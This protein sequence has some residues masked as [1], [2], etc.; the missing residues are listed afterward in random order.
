MERG[1]ATTSV[2]FSMLSKKSS[3]SFGVVY[4]CSAIV[5]P[6]SRVFL[7]C[8]M[9]SILFKLKL[10]LKTKKSNQNMCLNKHSKNIDCL[11]INLS[12][13]EFA[14]ISAGKLICFVHRYIHALPSTF[15]AQ[16]VGNSFTLTAQKALCNSAE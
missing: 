16:M 12:I 13:I 5:A 10:L 14:G 1:A 3:Q 4:N 6:S 15:R 2:G 8:A 9:R 7:V 11:L